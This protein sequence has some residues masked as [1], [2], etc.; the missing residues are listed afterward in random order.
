M[1]S[2]LIWLMQLLQMITILS[3]G[4]T[5][6]Q[7]VTFNLIENELRKQNKTYA[8]QCATF[9]LGF[10]PCRKLNNY[11]QLFE[12]QD[13]KMNKK[14][15]LWEQDM[16]DESFKIVVLDSE[17]YDTAKYLLG[18]ADKLSQIG[19]ITQGDEQHVFNEAQ[20]I[21]EKFVKEL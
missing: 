10:D 1:T 3:F 21:A 9:E 17:T 8:L 2:H 11:N 13:I 12:Q 7:Q 4:N 5:C 16:Y 18:K 19:S 15:K 14:C 20:K 6:A